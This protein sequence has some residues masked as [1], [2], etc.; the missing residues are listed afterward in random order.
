FDFYVHPWRDVALK[1]SPDA[2]A[3]RKPMILINGNF[4]AVNPQ[5][6]TAQQAFD[7]WVR[8][9]GFDPDYVGRYHA[10]QREGLHEMVGLTNHLAARFPEVTF[11]YRPHPFER[12]ATYRELLEPRE[13]L[14]L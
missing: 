5:F 7:R 12:L 2:Q 14:H 9:F 10:A 1:L 11:V 4:A 6:R 8:K 3:Y 13:N